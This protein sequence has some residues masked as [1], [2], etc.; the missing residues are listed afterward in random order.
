MTKSAVVLVSNLNCGRFSVDDMHHLAST[1]GNVKKLLMMPNLKKCLIQFC[2]RDYAQA[3]LALL[4]NQF[5]LGEKLKVNFSKYSKI[6]LRKNNRSCNSEKYNQVKRVS[7]REWRFPGK[8]PVRLTLIAPSIFLLFKIN[9][10][11]KNSITHE[12][13]FQRVRKEEFSPRQIKL[14]EDRFA[15]CLLKEYVA[16]G[17][18]TVARAKKEALLA[19]YKFKNLQE[20]MW[21]LSKLHNS[22]LSGKKL[23]VSFSFFKF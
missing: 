11:K 22:Q 15:E 8:S 19:I 3:C 10:N 12:T 9:Q 13:V 17:I 14:V 21:M 16:R 18:W 20:S 6:D 23:H 5:F 4:N 7:R 2:S 1:C